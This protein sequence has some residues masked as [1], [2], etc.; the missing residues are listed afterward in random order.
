M[1]VIDHRQFL[2][3]KANNRNKKK[4]LVL[5]L[6][7]I[8][9][10]LFI[11]ANIAT[12]L[13]YFNKVLPNYYLGS[14]PVGGKAYSGLSKQVAA[15]SLLPKTLKFSKNEKSKT[16]TPAQTGVHVDA[17]ASIAALKST[18][19]WLPL[20]S[21]FMRHTV[22]LQINLDEDTFAAS[23]SDLNTAL[24]KEPVKNHIEFNGQA[25]VEAPAKD[26]YKIDS[27]ALKKELLN[28]IRPGGSAVAVPTVIQKAPAAADLST[29]IA[30]LKKQITTKI[31]LA[32]QGKTVTP[33][34]KIIGGWYEA[35]GQSMALSAAKA[36]VYLDGIAPAAANRSDLILAI[37]YALN[38]GQPMSFAVAPKGSPTHTYCVQGRGAATN[39]SGVIG[40]LAATYADTRGWNGNGNMAFDYVDSGCEYTVWMSSAGQMASF[41]SICDS[42]YNCQVGANVILNE[43]RWK[44]GTDPWNAAGGNIEDYRVL[45]INHETGHRL[46]FGENNI[47]AAP[48]EPAFVM[49]QQS[50]DLKGCKFNIWPL[51]SELSKV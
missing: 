14:V 41:G 21:L 6:L 47:C 2:D 11:L 29:D 31:S 12:Y 40:K 32:Y 35:S 48:G 50:V 1:R 45:M 30:A 46:G 7:L 24:S 25:F 20:L 39:L 27:T 43:D 19:S 37:G 5:Y 8:L 22:P 28:T 10:G 23:A 17:D 9:L 44:S 33:D 15:D 3:K 34:E 38:N 4:R 26:G 36:G 18:H 51:L 49:M 16:L 13:I 42:Y